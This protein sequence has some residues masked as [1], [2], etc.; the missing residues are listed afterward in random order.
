LGNGHAPAL[1]PL[2]TREID[3]VRGVARGLTNRQIAAELSIA[4]RTVDTHVENILK[5]LRVRSRALVAAWAAQHAVAP[6][7]GAKKGAAVV[8][9]AQKG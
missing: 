5:K 1:A 4:E 7:A 2:T 6:P 8:R 9:H 3:I